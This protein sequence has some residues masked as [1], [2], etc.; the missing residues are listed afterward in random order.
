MLQE[1]SVLKPGAAQE[2]GQQPGRYCIHL[3]R[4]FTSAVNSKMLCLVRLASDRFRCAHTGSTGFSSW[5]YGGS[6]NTVSQD[7]AAI[8]SAIASLVWVL[9]LSQ[10]STIGPPGVYQRSWTVT[11]C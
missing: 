10:T 6:R 4:V 8:S 9:R 5:A 3:S 1:R 11:P 7:R 2:P